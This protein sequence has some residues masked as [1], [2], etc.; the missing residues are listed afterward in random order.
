MGRPSVLVL[1]NYTH[2]H[3][4][5]HLVD[6]ANFDRVS[7]SIWPGY[8]PPAGLK[9]SKVE[10]ADYHFTDISDVLSFE[11]LVDDIEP[12]I[13]IYADPPPLPAALYPEN[14]T[15]DLLKFAR[16]SPHTRI[17]I[18]TYSMVM[19]GNKYTHFID[20]SFYCGAV[21][22]PYASRWGRSKFMAEQ[23]VLLANN[24]PTSSSTSWTGLVP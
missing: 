8:K 24:P 14:T 2:T 19:K 16:E 12:T 3:L 1:G 21:S 15:N 22:G 11:E 5:Q 23:A 17:L 7:V 10:G 20:P 4:V 18:H 9:V 6:S 13:I